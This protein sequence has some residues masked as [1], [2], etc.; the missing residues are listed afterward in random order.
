MYFLTPLPV[1]ELLLSV[2]QHTSRADIHSISM[3]GKDA[4]PWIY[5]RDCCSYYLSTLCKSTFTSRHWPDKVFSENSELY[6]PV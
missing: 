5:I 1:A 6:S 2:W 3:L 4:M